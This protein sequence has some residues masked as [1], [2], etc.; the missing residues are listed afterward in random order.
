M[1]V[2]LSSS[3]PFKILDGKMWHLEN[4]FAHWVFKIYIKLKSIQGWVKVMSMW[5]PLHLHYF[6]LISILFIYITT[7]NLL[8]PTAVYV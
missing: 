7:I 4:S 3:L 2:E 1:Y 8:L 5:K 6:L